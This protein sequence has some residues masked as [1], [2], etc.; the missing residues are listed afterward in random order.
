M[1]RDK[2]NNRVRHVMLLWLGSA[3]LLAVAPAAAEPPAVVSV[4]ANA[5]QVG[6]Y[7]KV[8]LRLDLDASFTN[9]FD[10]D[11]IDLC[12]EFT[13][14]SGMHT[15]RTARKPGDGIGTLRSGGLRPRG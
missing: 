7:E 3:F 8:E 4:E 10:P 9:P 6:L 14:P 1:T 13:A 12:A 15:S 2:L 11:Q 5:E